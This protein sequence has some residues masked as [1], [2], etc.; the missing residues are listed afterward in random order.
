[1]YTYTFVPITIN[2]YKVCLFGAVI[3]LFTDINV[4]PE[5]V[6]EAVPEVAP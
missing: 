2:V 5:Q 4:N 6:N 3:P 1:M